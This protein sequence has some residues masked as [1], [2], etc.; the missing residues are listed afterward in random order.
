MIYSQI[1][2]IVSAEKFAVS[3]RSVDK[4]FGGEKWL[5]G[6]TERSQ[7][8]PENMLVLLLMLSCASGHLLDTRLGLLNGR[9]TRSRDG[10]KYTAFTGVP[11]AKPPTGGLRLKNPEPVEPWGVRNATDPSP[12]CPQTDGF[13]NFPGV[14]PKVIGQEDCLYLNVYTPETAR[15]FPVLVHIHGGAFRMGNPGPRDMADYFMDEDVVLVTINYRL[16]VLG[17][18]STEDGEVTGNFG[19]KDQSMAIRWVSENIAAFGGDPSKITVF[20]ESAGGASAHYQ[21]YSEL[22]EDLVKGAISQ[23]GAVNRVWSLAEHGLARSRAYL[24]AEKAG[25]RGAQ[26]AECLRKVDFEKLV[27]LGDNL[28]TYWDMDDTCPYRPV[29]EAALP[30]AFLT[31]DPSQTKLVKPWLTGFTSGEGQLKT[32]VLTWKPASV[33][34]E[35]LKRMDEIIP[36]NLNMDPDR[37]STKEAL[38]KIKSRYFSKE[39]TKDLMD[40]YEQYFADVVFIYPAV[41]SAREHKGPVY[42]YQLEHRCEGTVLDMIAKFNNTRPNHVDEIFLLFNMKTKQG[43]KGTD[44]DYTLSK[45]TVKLWV[46]F[47][48]E[49]NPTP[50]GYGV[51]WPRYDTTGKY[52]RI[53]EGFPVGDDPW[54]DTMAFWDDVLNSHSAKEE[55]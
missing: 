26:V 19:L 33:W 47:A 40:G 14:E 21:L 28:F 17:F 9:E 53:K 31:R 25:C 41:K 11:Y 12:L 48:S 30:G 16:G 2:K 7:C 46:N 5:A 52:L 38:K 29:V 1:G 6:P 45:A 24:L 15:K 39:D 3:S 32:I 49:Q 22:T 18:L 23:S 44:V 51:V 43:L 10:R 36:L 50:P 34:E 20:G 55:L 8:R 42:L 27:L 35:F 37:T 54:D 4:T 13:F